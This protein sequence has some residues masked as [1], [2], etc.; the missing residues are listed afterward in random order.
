MGVDKSLEEVREW[1]DKIYEEDK[2]LTDEQIF[3]KMKAETSDVI[4]AL[5]LKTYTK[6]GEIRAN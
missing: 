3:K 6:P 4:A 2:N 1:K 5:G